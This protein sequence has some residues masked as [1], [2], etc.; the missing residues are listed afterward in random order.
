ME[1]IKGYI[2]DII[3]RNEENL[4]TVFELTTADGVLTCTGTPASL[5]VGKTAF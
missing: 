5:N 2:S 3:F 4:Y 1:E